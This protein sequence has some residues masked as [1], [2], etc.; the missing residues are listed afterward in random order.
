MRIPMLSH[1]R[2][3]LPYGALAMLPDTSREA[4]LTK[5]V[6]QTVIER[7][8]ARIKDPLTQLLNRRG[9]I[10][11]LEE[12]RSEGRRFAILSMDL[13]NF[14]LIND[15]LGHA[16]GDT[17]LIAMSDILLHSVRSEDLLA[18]RMG[19][20][21][22]LAGLD[23][24]PRAAVEAGMT[25]EKRIETTASRL[26]SRFNEEAKRIIEQAYG[27]RPDI[28]ERIGVT[29]GYDMFNPEDHGDVDGILLA[30]DIEMR[31]QKQDAHRQA[32]GAYRPTI[33]PDF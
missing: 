22:F 19:G 10:E 24:T 17:I 11:G 1:E 13:T 33:S 4:Q 16:L 27:P 7:E 28:T 25:N 30:A 2:E 31:A 5:Y 18:A 29:I 8:D 3:A 6:V 14:K 12:W 9:F 23:L 32:G 21:E 15:E 26:A 20:D